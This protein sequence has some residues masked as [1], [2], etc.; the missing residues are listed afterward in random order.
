[1]AEKKGPQGPTSLIYILRISSPKVPDINLLTI[2]VLQKSFSPHPN[3]PLDF[4]FSLEV[5]ARFGARTGD[6]WSSFEPTP[7]EV[8]EPMLFA[9]NAAQREEKYVIL[10]EAT[11]HAVK[12]Q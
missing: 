7:Y 5:R 11:R 9:Y 6:A 1:M 8:L 2:A 10:V 4:C 12:Q 3:P